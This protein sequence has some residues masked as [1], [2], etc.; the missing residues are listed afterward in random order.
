MFIKNKRYLNG[1]KVSFR[2]HIIEFKGGI[3]EV[4]EDDYNALLT[5]SGF[6]K[7]GA[8]AEKP[9]EPKVE[10]PAE[11]KKEE[12]AE[13]AEPEDEEVDFESMNIASLV[14]YATAHNI[15][16]NK[17]AKKSEIIAEITKVIK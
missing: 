14:K 12:K 16:V 7:V 11:P 9:T 6:E 8:E 3:A 1:G 15:K 4:S 10:S 17:N 5:V 13:V 2:G